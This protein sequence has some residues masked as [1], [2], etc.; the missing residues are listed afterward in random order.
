M[1]GQLKGERSV[2]DLLVDDDRTDLSHDLI[3]RINGGR[4]G[5]SQILLSKSIEVLHAPV[6]K[7]ED[8]DLRYAMGWAAWRF[9]EAVNDPT[10]E[11]PLALSR[12]GKWLGSSYSTPASATICASR[13]I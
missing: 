7:T 13:P 5:N 4:Y 2:P 12:G 1:G 11:P 9:C 6:L 8:R 3:A 10:A